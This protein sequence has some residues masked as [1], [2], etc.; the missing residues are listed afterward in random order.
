MSTV[1]LS[2]QKTGL[3][4]I[5][6]S[7]WNRMLT[8]EALNQFAQNFANIPANK[9]PSLYEL[10][11]ILYRLL[12]R[13]RYYFKS[14]SRLCCFLGN[15]S[16]TARRSPWIEIRFSTHLK[17]GAVRIKAKIATVAWKVFLQTFGWFH[18]HIWNLSTVFAFLVQVFHLNIFIVPGFCNFW[19]DQF[20]WTSAN[21]VLRLFEKYQKKKHLNS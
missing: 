3:L 15:R 1:P 10:G 14:D 8:Q 9:I 11:F 18:W 2:L 12:Q 21:N 5:H 13:Y 20:A 7:F 17:F 16:S 19:K 6:I 4:S